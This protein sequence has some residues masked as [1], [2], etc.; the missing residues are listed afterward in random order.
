MKKLFAAFCTLLL[1]SFQATASD[2]KTSYEGFYWNEDKSA[3]I[4]LRLTED[5]IEGI[6]A[7]GPP[8]DAKDTKNPDKELQKRNIIGLTFLWGFEYAAKKNRW[9]NGK[10]YDPKNGKTY[11]AK[12]TL[13][14]GGNTLEMRGYVGVSIL[15]RTAKFQR[16]KTEN[17]PAG[18]LMAVKSTLKTE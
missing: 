18:L 14:N 5:S 13:K 9:K 3:I 16:V 2:I 1:M 10:V 4:E 6:T 15:G 17:I 12:M 8:E 7:W 11:D